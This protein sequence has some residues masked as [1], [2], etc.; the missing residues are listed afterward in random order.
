MAST[1]RVRATNNGDTG[2]STATARSRR[3][4]SIATTRLPISTVV[5]IVARRNS[6]DRQFCTGY[7]S[8]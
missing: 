7:L 4:R 3:P 2:N 6:I 1:I 5:A 8:Y